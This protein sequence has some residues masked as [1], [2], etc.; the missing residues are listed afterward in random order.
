MRMRN[1]GNDM[2]LKLVDNT[3]I[4]I[5]L[6]NVFLPLANM[7]QEYPFVKLLTAA[8]IPWRTDSLAHGREPP[9]SSPCEPSVHFR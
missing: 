4:K 6:T 2:R 3:T 7:S 5:T 1:R 8:R 9:I